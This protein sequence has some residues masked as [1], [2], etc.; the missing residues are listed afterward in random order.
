MAKENVG[1]I[2]PSHVGE[3]FVSCLFDDS[4]VVNGQPILEPVIVQGIM[5]KFG[6]HPVRL[7]EQRK[8]IIPLI[9]QLSDGF[10]G[11]GESF[12]NMCMTKEGELWTGSHQT[13]EQ[14]MVLSI[15]LKIA[16][17]TF[18]RETWTDLPGG[19]PYVSFHAQT[20]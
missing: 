8:Y 4:E 12:L 16:S 18:E 14:L 9:E 7:E 15:G 20:A 11:D 13:C 19:V 5:G 10:K 6:F 1:M 3:M 2:S 17:Y